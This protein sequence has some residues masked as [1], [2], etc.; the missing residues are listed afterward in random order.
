MDDCPADAIDTVI[1]A[2]MGGETIAG[3]LERAP[4]TRK[5]QMILQPMSKAAQLRCWLITNGYAIQ[6]EQLVRDAGIIYPILTAQGTSSPSYTLAEL[7]YGKY[8]VISQ[9][10]LFPEYRDN[11]MQKLRHALRG[12][13]RAKS[14]E[15][16][17]RCRQIMEIISDIEQYDRRK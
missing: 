11:L 1:I 12:L 5:K 13:N 8:S 6:T 15:A 9:D 4:W 3:I 2:G 17:Q 7:Y 16:K 10:P 14:E